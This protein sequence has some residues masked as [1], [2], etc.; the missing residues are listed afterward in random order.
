[1]FCGGLRR[2]EDLLF[3]SSSLLSRL[4]RNTFPSDLQAYTPWLKPANVKQKYLAR[5]VC[6]SDKQRSLKQFVV[7]RRLCPK[8]ASRLSRLLR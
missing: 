8:L 1:M 6:T 7:S 2:G 4:G 5:A 3:L